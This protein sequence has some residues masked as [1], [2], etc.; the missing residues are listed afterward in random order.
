MFR[1]TPLANTPTFK[2]I[3]GF[4]LCTLGGAMLYAYFKQRDE[5]DE[6]Q[7]QDTTRNH[8]QKPKA[9]SRQSS[10]TASKQAQKEVKL[11]FK[12]SNEHV[13]LIAGRQGAN[14]K[15]IQDRTQTT[16]HFRDKDDTH[17]LC[18]ITGHPDNVKEAR[19]ILLKEIERSPIV[20][21]EIYVPQSVCGKIMGRCGEAMQEICRISLAKVS[22]DAGVRSANTRRITITG[23]RQQV[24]IARKMIED[25]IEED[26]NLRRAVEEVEQKREPRRSPANSVNSSMYSSQTSLSS[27]LPPREKLM[28]ARNDEKP[29]EVYVSAIASPAKFWVQLI[30]PQTKKLDDLVANMTAYYSNAENRAMHQIHEP[31][32]GQ[33]VATVFKHDNKWYRAEVVGILPNQYNPNEVVLDLYFVDYGDSE[34]VLPHEIFELRTDFLTLRF[35][36]VECFLANVKSTL[37]SDPQTWEPQSIEFFEDFTQVAR[38]KKLIS[39]VVTYKDRVKTLTGN[40]AAREGSPIPGVELYD[41]QEG[42]EIN[43]GHMMISHGYALPISEDYPRALSP[44]TASLSNS[45]DALTNSST[46]SSSIMKPQSPQ[47]PLSPAYS[48]DA[49]SAED[50]LIEEQLKHLKSATPFNKYVNGSNNIAVT[51]M[52]PSEFF[53]GGGQTTNSAPITKATNGHHNNMDASTAST[54]YTNGNPQR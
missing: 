24:N 8:S 11:E 50:A 53:N 13:P 2:L 12:I 44:Y 28:A 16:I 31:Y 27:H 21:E 29:M 20:K 38:W 18:E 3:L 43:L 32:L 37:I 39:R 25:K 52:T 26:E 33:I 30:G 17:K 41:I 22:V 54:L 19:S 36:A 51:K 45:N 23:N 35:Q 4:G 48:N 5:D 15:S 47:P 9:I 46:T 42:I 14:L 40:A 49:D 34:Y 1:N 6:D 7:K 10:Q